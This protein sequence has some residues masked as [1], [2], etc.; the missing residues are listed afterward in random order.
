MKISK[1]FSML[2]LTTGFV[3]SI[4]FISASKG[5]GEPLRTNISLEEL[6]IGAMEN[7]ATAKLIKIEAINGEIISLNTQSSLDLGLAANLGSSISRAETLS[8][9]TPT[10]SAA[11][12]FRVGISKYLKS[13]TQID[14]SMT[15]GD[16][17]LEFKPPTGKVES[18]SGNVAITARQNLLSDGFG[19]STRL[20]IEA[21]NEIKKATEHEI[22]DRLENYAV[23]I[24]QV[25]FNTR[26]AQLLALSSD[27]NLRKQD[28]LLEIAKILRKR[29]NLEKSDVLQFRASRLGALNEKHNASANL[30]Q[31]W[32]SAITLLGLPKAYKK[33]PAL[34]IEMLYAPRE[35]TVQEICNPS[36][37]VDL[38]KTNSYLALK[39]K[40]TGS[41]KTLAASKNR[42]LPNLAL[43]IKHATQNYEEEYGR[44]IADSWS[45]KNPETSVSLSFSTTIENSSKKARAFE[46]AKNHEK[47][48]VSYENFVEDRLTKI[49]NECLELARSSERSTELEQIYTNQRERAK[50]DF[51]RFELGRIEPFSAIQSSIAETSAWAG[52]EMAKLD[53]EMS[54]WK[55]LYL[56]GNIENSLEKPKHPQ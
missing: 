24:S 42:A 15:T 49:E 34:D 43:E 5:L 50:L 14:L 4:F 56:T 17:S 29:G 38:K 9:A 46:D 3:S 22:K 10:S 30:Q 20:S 47:N 54:A 48:R 37:S 39:T 40:L 31:L 16:T 35:S 33:V 52:K 11:N 44:A 27:E 6:I 2:L 12:S 25:F 1:S 53:V 51:K 7:S 21:A 8:F 32:N 19:S 23:D 41:E 45:G 18:K 28:R 36:E 13:G 55:I 26:K